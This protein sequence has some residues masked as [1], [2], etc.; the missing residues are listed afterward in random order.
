MALRHV[1]RAYGRTSVA[2]RSG[3]V[4]QVMYRALSDEGNPE[5]STLKALLDAM[6]LR[7]A[8]EQK[9]KASQ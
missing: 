3:I 1:A 7:L 5:L 9:K 2:K 8:L 4:H 6:G